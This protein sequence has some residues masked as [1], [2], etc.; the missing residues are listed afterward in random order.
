AVNDIHEAIELRK[1]GIEV[2]ILIFGVP[3]AETGDLYKRFDLTA[4]VSAL[5]HFQ[6]LPEGTS[7][8]LNFSTG[9]GRLGFRSEEA[10]KVAT[11]IKNH[12][13]LHCSGIYSHLATADELDS[14]K[15]EKQYQ[16]FKEI[17]AH[18]DSGLS[19]H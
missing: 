1:S 13:G 6:L 5:S 11:I 7:Y 17:R 8:H 18:F 15:A 16:L 2:P 9:M 4:T 12:P 14:T 19:A 3:E 10:K